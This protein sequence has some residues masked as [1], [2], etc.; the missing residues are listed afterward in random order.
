ME[1][2]RRNESILSVSPNPEVAHMWDN[3]QRLL[4]KVQGTKCPRIEPGFFKTKM[5]GMF[6][7]IIII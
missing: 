6:R 4:E 7:K 3:E 5:N 2:T 1:A